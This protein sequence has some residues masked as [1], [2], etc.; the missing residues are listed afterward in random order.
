[1]KRD[2]LKRLRWLL[3]ILLVALAAGQAVAEPHR[4][5]ERITQAE[6]QAMSLDAAVAMVRARFGG[7]IIGA[8]TTHQRGRTVHVIKLLSDEGRVR[9][10]RVDAQTGR[11]L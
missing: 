2:S 7:K 11:I 5:H 6:G 10:V 1:M 9:T 8:S 3:P 4:P